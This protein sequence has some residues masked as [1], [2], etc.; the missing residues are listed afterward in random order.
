MKR[1][2]RS[3]PRHGEPH[4]D[5]APGNGA[6]DAP[7]LLGEPDCGGPNAFL[8]RMAL[9]VALS[10]AERIVLGRL[11]TAARAIRPRTDLVREGEDPGGATVILAGAACRY[12]LRPTGTRHIVGYLLPGDICEADAV[13]N[14]RADASLAT[15]SPC[16]IVSLPRAAL[17][18]ML[19]LHAG[20]ARGLR[21]AKLVEE[22][23]LRTWLANLGSRSALERTAHLFCEI[24]TRLRMIGL[25]QEAQVDLPMT[26][27]DLSLT[28]GMSTV[29]M[30][31]TLHELRRRGI[32]DLR[33]RTL[34]LL[35]RARLEAVAEFDPGYLSP[36]LAP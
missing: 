1:F 19:S 34:H 7:S 32:A 16:T 27:L 22:A 24:G 3:G 33:G 18:E 14:R 17:A 31:R 5:E 9:S 30:N 36:V 15:L 21:A 28:L 11:G 35:D 25:A 10:P 2:D 20:I 12:K 26:Q 23:T 8:R 4:D 29:H 13:L 6:A